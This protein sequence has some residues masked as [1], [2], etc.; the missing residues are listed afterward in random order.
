VLELPIPNKA[1]KD[2]LDGKGHFKIDTDQDAWKL[3]VDNNQ[4]FSKDKPVVADVTLDLDQGSKQ[5]EFGRDGGLKLGISGSAGFSHQVRILWPDK[6][7]D[8][9]DALQYGIVIPQKSIYARLQLSGQAGGAADAKF[10]VGPL[11]ATVGVGAGGHAKYE[12]WLLAAANAPALQVLTDLYAGLRLPQSIDQANELPADGELFVL[13]YGGYLKLNAGLSWGYELKGSKSIDVPRMPLDLDYQLRAMASVDVGYQIA[14]EYQI[15]ARKAADKWVRFTVRK[16]RSSETT[17][18]VDFGFT[19]EYTLRGLPESADEFLSKLFGA[20][21]DRIL[22]LFHQGQKYSDLKNLE[23]A[24][25]KLLKSTVQKYSDQVLG[26]VLSD[27]TVQ[28]VIQ[29]MQQV[30]GDYANFDKRII[31]LYHDVLKEVVPPGQQ[32]TLLKTINAFLGAAKK[33]DLAGLSGTPQFAA[34]VDLLRRLYNEKLFDVLQT[35]ATFAEAAGLLKHA[36]DFIEGDSAADEQI[37]QWIDMVQKEVP[38][39]DLLKK[40]AGMDKDALKNLADEK[41]QGLV[42]KLLGKAFAAM[43][44]SDFGKAADLVNKNFKKIDDFKNKFYADAVKQVTHQSFQMDLHLAYSRAR[45]N[46]KLLEVE[47]NLAHPDGRGAERANAAAAG[48]YQD[49]LKNYDT[50]AV[51]VIKGLFS[52]E[53][54]NSMS[55]KFNVLGFGTEG[56]VTL[57]QRSEEALEPRDGGLLHVYTSETY[58]ERKRTAGGKFKET[59]DSKFLV[60]A[61]GESFQKEGTSVKPYAIDVLRSMTSSFD[62]FQSDDDTRPEELTE[63]LRFAGELGLL[64]QEPR[65]YVQQLTDACGGNL[66]KVKLTYRVG[67]DVVALH[68]A[69]KFAGPEDPHDLDGG[70]LGRNVRKAMRGF[71]WRKFAS[72]DARDWFS[73]VAFAY[74]SDVFYKLYRQHA[75]TSEPR[76]VT[77][78]GWFTGIGTQQVSLRPMPDLALLDRLFRFEDDMVAGVLAVDI[79]VAALDNLPPGGT[80]DWEKLNAAILQM[81]KA[82]GSV[83]EYDDSCFP[84]ILDRLIQ[85]STNGTAKRDSTLLLEVTPSKGSVKGTI[86]RLISS[87]PK[88][89]TEIATDETAQ[90]VSAAAGGN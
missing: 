45:K 73:R 61:V 81:V 4:P 46:E 28:D 24:A 43:N 26:I 88:N 64:D 18:A 3:L 63:Y 25:G 65:L 74:A 60:Q 51:R 19:G 48:D 33:E 78:P 55:V 5:F 72:A 59:V 71:I 87:G 11:S 41:L 67:F 75:L 2:F 70:E 84:V 6:D 16:S 10:P 32:A 15:E 68:S 47:V 79:Q 38:F 13:G 83:A 30:S 49:L 69:F 44:D 80:I 52:T 35:D 62:L 86:T 37:K 8:I 22:E 40:L 82:A 57:F 23:E 54:R 9:A 34:I 89:P 66:G 42:E 21:A 36:K 7:S 77:M 50:T 14:G 90:L 58:V 39:N 31:D 53:L 85:T 29:K 12:R 1:G 20:H 17:L 27:A 56:L 76:G